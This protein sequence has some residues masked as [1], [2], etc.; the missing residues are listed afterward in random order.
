MRARV[1]L[2]L[3]WIGVL[4]TPLA[5]CASTTAPLI[6]LPAAPAA[7]PAIIVVSGKC[8]PDAALPARKTMKRVPQTDTYMDQV[9]GLLLDERRDH[10]AD[11]DDYNSL[12]GQCAGPAS[13]K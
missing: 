7:A 6:S 5:G 1:F 12:Y 8:H 11:I 13:T 2:A 4:A 10:K 9:Y 3:L